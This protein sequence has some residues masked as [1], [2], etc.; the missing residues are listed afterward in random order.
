MLKIN[1]K[2][3]GLN[4]KPKLISEIS[5]NH[6]GKLEYAIKLIRLAAKNGS[7]FI[8]LQTY[9]PDGITLNSNKKDFVIKNKKSLWHNRNLYQL[10]KS[11]STPREWHYKLFNESKKFNVPMFTSIFN[12]KDIE[13]LE[14]LNVPAYKIASF[15]FNHFPLIEKVSKTKKPILIST[16]M[17]KL[18]EINE[19]IKFLRKIKCNKFA[20]LKCTSSYP[21]NSLSINLKT[22]S[23]MRKRFKCEVGYSDHTIG[24][25][26]SIGSIHYGATFIEKH[27]CLNNN[28]GLDAK[29]SLP[30]KQLQEFKNELINAH[31][32][33][34]KIFYGT[35]QNEKNNLQFRRSIYASKKI[36]KNEILTINNI[37]VVRP[38]YGLEPRYFT[39]ILGKKV[40][41]NINYADP[42]FLKFLK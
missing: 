18:K 35:T 32:T 13:F 10:Y 15:E 21:A 2:N 17:A 30:V 27:I 1:K 40:K 3:I 38:S 25:A 14:R 4:E 7:D 36:K 37:K 16:G 8:K 9:D 6:G 31:N 12:E 11:G 42:I 33:Q 29:F 34:G 41:K 24:Y 5:A 39:K 19:L 26:A 28:I 23:D 20:L 22:I